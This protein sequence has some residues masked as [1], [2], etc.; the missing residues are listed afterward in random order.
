M[1]QRQEST[2]KVAATAEGDPGNKPVSFDSES[3]EGRRETMRSKVRIRVTYVATLFLFLG[4]YLLVTY[5]ALTGSKQ[6]AKDLFLA[7]LP[8]SAAVISFW[9]AKRDS[10]KTT[11]TNDGG[12]ER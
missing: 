5:L 9:F 1:S 10:Q 11:R 2:S 7:I 8:I 4:G 3:E 12:N 6:E